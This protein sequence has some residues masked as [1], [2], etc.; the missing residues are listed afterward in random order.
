[1]PTSPTDVP[2]TGGFLRTFAHP[3]FDLQHPAD[4]AVVMP[5]LLRPVMIDALQSVFAQAFR[6]RI[7]VL[8]GIDVPCEDLA[9]LDY[10]CTNRPPHCAVQVLYPGYSTSSRHGGLAAPQDGGVL[11]TVL[12]YLANSPLVA[13]LDDDNR[14]APGHL[15]ALCAAIDGTAW[16]YA[17]RWFVHP[18]TRRA[19]CLDEWESV[20]PDAGV[21]RERFGGFVD[22]NCL[23]IDK[24]RCLEAL[25]L[26]S[27]PLAGDWTGL[28]ADRAVFDL[29]RRWPG[30]ASGA[31][32]VLYTMNAQDALHPARLQVM[33]QRYADAGPP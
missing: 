29:L 25:P 17:L 11:R 4:V 26:W 28:T 18:H 6:G 22:P 31:A 32:T 27:T 21:Y 13:Y 20:G 3:G 1:M 14:W 15:A 16:A 10:A 7:H 19:V 12:S 2:P 23:M 33:G 9:I 30:R 24:A 5:T 8:L